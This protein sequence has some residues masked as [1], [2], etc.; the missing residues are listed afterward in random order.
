VLREDVLLDQLS[1]GGT[2][3]FRVEEVPP[4]EYS[5]TEDELLVPVAHF[6]KEIYQTFGIPF[7]MKIKHVSFT[8]IGWAFN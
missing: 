4:D 5:L 2:R 6:H 1:V 3:T 8:V 7:L